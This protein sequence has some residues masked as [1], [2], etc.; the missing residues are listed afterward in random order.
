MYTI[1]IET[2]K[3]H[4]KHLEKWSPYSSGCTIMSSRANKP[5][6]YEEHAMAK[7]KHPFPYLTRNLEFPAFSDINQQ[8]FVDL[9]RQVL[10]LNSINK[11]KV[12]YTF[13]S[14]HS[15]FPEC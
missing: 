4:D 1:S 12:I 11:Y 6:R 7:D 5:Q 3:I 15:A 9:F 13:S 14:Y 10:K 8:M 2:R